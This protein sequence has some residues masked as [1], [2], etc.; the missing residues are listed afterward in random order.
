MN[1]LKHTQNIKRKYTWS[2]GVDNVIVIKGA[3]I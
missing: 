1:K 2:L 3:K